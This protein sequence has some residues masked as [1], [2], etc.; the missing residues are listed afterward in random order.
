MHDRLQHQVVLLYEVFRTPHQL[1]LK[2]DSSPILHSF[3]HLDVALR[4]VNLLLEDVFEVLH[5]TL[6][7]NWPGLARWRHKDLVTVLLFRLA[8]HVKQDLCEK[9]LHFGVFEIL[10]LQELL[11]IQS[12]VQD[13]CELNE[14][15]VGRVLLKVDVSRNEPIKHIVDF[16][17]NNL[18]SVFDFLGEL[19]LRAD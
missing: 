9:V 5:A 10:Q 3:D 4:E 17:R 1:V 12:H 15:V 2:N 18:V 13:F 14:M 11:F 8:T 7:V 6:A 19:V 16:S